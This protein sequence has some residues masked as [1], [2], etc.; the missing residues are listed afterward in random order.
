MPAK[1]YLKC[2]NC[3]FSFGYFGPKDLPDDE[4]TEIKTCPCGALMEETEELY[5]NVWREDE[6]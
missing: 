1:M 3:G 4:M 5:A 6:A 2:P